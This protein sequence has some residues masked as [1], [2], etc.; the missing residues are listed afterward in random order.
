MRILDKHL[1]AL[2][3]ALDVFSPPIGSEVYLFGSRAD[4]TQHGGDI[5]IL[6]IVSEKTFD[7]FRKQRALIKTRLQAAADDQRVD[8]TL[9]TPDKMKKDPFLISLDRRVLLKKYN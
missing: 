2:L 9:A 3:G 4:D 7:D 1:K 5:D 6:L 8:L